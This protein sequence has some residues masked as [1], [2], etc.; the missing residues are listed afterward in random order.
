VRI[1]RTNHAALLLATLLLL[2]ASGRVDEARFATPPRSPRFTPPAAGVILADDFSGSGILPH[3][4]VDRESVWT[5]SRGMLRADLPDVKQLRSLIRAGDSTWIDYAVDVDV[6]MMRGVDKGVVV[7]VEGDNG[8][9]IDL[10]S[11]SYQDVVAYLREWPMGKA[12]ATNAN[13]VWNHL[14]VEMRG[15]RLRVRVNG[16]LRLERIDARRARARG[17]IALPAY[18]GG[19]GKCTVYY[20]NVVVT[21]LD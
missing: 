10:R 18:T 3:W 1:P 16:E 20:D 7:R 5:I 4:R 6:C 13:G 2:G 12:Q 8:I 19:I 15:N 9:G 17:G 11:G 21:K 14:R